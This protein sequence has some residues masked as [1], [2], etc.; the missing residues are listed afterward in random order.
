MNLTA[1]QQWE[2]DLVKERLHVKCWRLN[3]D[4]KF[5][6][7]SSAERRP[8]GYVED[9]PQL[10][11]YEYRWPELIKE[12]NDALDR[13]IVKLL[14]TLPREDRSKLPKLDGDSLWVWGGPT[15][16]WGG[17][18]AEDTLVKGADYFGA[19]N[20]VYVYGETSEKN[21][22]LHSKYHRMLCQINGNCR[23]PGM[24]GE[25][26]DERNAEELSRLSLTYPNVVGAM[27]DDVTTD[28]NKIVLPEAFEARYR[29]LKKYNDKLKMYGVIYVHELYAKNFS[30]IQ[31]Y[32]DV[33]NLW[34][35]FRDD[36][37]NYDAHIAKCRECF[38]GKKIIQ[39]IFIQD[40]GRG[41][42][43]STPELLA[44][45]LD[46]VREYMAKGVVEGAIILGDREIKKWPTTA[47]AVKDYLEQQ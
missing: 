39:G 17:T 28:Y 42:C 34:F 43:G 27:C 46:K 16:Y 30:L 29:G 15:P 2:L 10:S 18:M 44:Y 36:I 37:L 40:Y 5:D 22:K 26:D 32:L 1:E 13:E 12:E 11:K 14:K 20:V 47:K 31:D 8:E 7:S 25:F 23:T 35:W 33:V 41:A 9:D 38:P 45:Q 3:V 24:Q 21:M 6:P 4:R 19:K